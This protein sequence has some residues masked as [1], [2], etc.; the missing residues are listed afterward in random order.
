MLWF[1]LLPDKI[2]GRVIR[3]LPLSSDQGSGRHN[4]RL[5]E[6]TGRKA[7]QG[8][9]LFLLRVGDL[10][11]IYVKCT[12]FPLNVLILLMNTSM[13]SEILFL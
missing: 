13:F 8:D 4:M 5:P 12:G 10:I 7:R 1:T 2:A 3:E 9:A 6:E 11:E